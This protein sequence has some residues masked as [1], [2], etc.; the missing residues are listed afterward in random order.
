MRTLK[1]AIAGACFAIGLSANDA[2]AQSP[3]TVAAEVCNEAGVCAPV[4][5]ATAVIIIG[6]AQL[7]TEL[8]KKE[9]FGPNNDL[10][11]SIKNMI[12]DLTHGPGANNDALKVL[13]N[14]GSDL[15]CGPG[16]NNDVVKFLAGLG[17]HVGTTAPC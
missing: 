15:R 1:V 17:I 9:P 6:L 14:I 10:V 16:P 7:A 5:P 8:N 11:K 12:N 13:H 3:G 4:D 2:A